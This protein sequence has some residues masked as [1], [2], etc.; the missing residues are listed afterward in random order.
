MHGAVA[1]WLSTGFTHPGALMAG[2]LSGPQ[3][4]REPSVRWG[5][6]PQAQPLRSLS[7]PRPALPAPHPAPLGCGLV[8][9]EPS[10]HLFLGSS[11]SAPHTAGAQEGW[12]GWVKEPTEDERGWCLWALFSPREAALAEIRRRGRRVATGLDLAACL[13]ADAGDG[14]GDWNREQQSSR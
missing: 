4:R 13:R 12:H 6:G 8:R 7:D 1:L 11:S 3:N 9:M 14:L 10:S 5:A 2:H